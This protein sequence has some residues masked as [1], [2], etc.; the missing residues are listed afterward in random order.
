[1]LFSISVKYIHNME[2]SEGEPSQHSPTN[3]ERPERAEINFSDKE[4]VVKIAD[5]TLNHVKDY[6]DDR[7]GSLKR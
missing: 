4:T 1:M 5:I 3:S 7:F 2:N 6:F